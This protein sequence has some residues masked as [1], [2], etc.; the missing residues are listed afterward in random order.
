[1][2]LL[3]KIAALF[4]LVSL[5]L[6]VFAS[7]EN[8]PP[9]KEPELSITV[10][11]EVEIA[12]GSSIQLEAVDGDGSIVKTTWSASNNCVTVS[13]NGEVTGTR[14]GEA[15]VTATHNGVTDKVLVKVTENRILTLSVDN[16]R[17]AE[18]ETATLTTTLSPAGAITGEIA[19][20]IMGDDQQNSFIT[21]KDGKITAKRPGGTLKITAYIV[22]TYVKS[23]TV[24]VYT[25]ST[26]STPPD[27][28]PPD[29]TPPDTTPPNDTPPDDIETDP[30]ENVNKTTFYANY[31]PAKSYTDATYRTK[32]GLMSGSITVP[33]Q[34]PTIATNRPTYDGKFIL[35]TDMIYLDNGKTYVVVDACGDEA[36]R[37]YHGG[38]YITLEEVAAYLYAFGEI[39][40]NYTSEKKGN[41]VPSSMWSTW[42]K[43]L[44]LNHTNFSGDTSKYPYEPELP[45]I[46][47]CGGSLQYKEVDIGS[48]GYNN[49]SSITRDTSRIVYGRSDLNRNGK[50]DVGELYLFYTYNHYND[51]QEYLNYLGGWGEMFGNFTG[52]GTGNPTPYVPV[53]RKSFSARTAAVACEYVIVTF[54]GSY[55]RKESNA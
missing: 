35:N 20:E 49:G 11:D 52:G 39:P 21:F 50:Y 51:F 17:L 18:G 43:Y 29:T 9:V 31:T 40:P 55:I 47:G 53:V 45:N 15:I 22:G 37:I 38:A 19:Y 6:G 14:V 5:V 25:T 26:D 16:E 30:Y 48:H 24:T 27:T 7:C 32:H 44:R 54:L 23:N 34:A 28:T 36:I 42:G 41:R 4:L 13:I 33:D 3:Q 12:L 10:G 46:S 2:K 8:T 1:M